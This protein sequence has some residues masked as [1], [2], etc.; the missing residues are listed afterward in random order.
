MAQ[1]KREL[2]ELADVS[3][4]IRG[5]KAVQREAKKATQAL[6]ELE[7][8]EAAISEI[9][10]LAAFI[11]RE[12]PHEPGRYTSESA[13]DVAVRLLERVK[14]AEKAGYNPVYYA[15]GLRDYTTDDLRREIAYREAV[16][17]SAV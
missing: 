17:V 10:R 12:Y 4:M 13:V 15:S 1:E 11:Q 9:G 2:N 3:E 8:A 16:E 14:D 5:L 7:G 6:R